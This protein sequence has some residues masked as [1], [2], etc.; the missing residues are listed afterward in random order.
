[1]YICTHISDRYSERQR[2][3]YKVKYTFVYCWMHIAI[4]VCTKVYICENE[5]RIY[6]VCVYFVCWACTWSLSGRWLYS[7]EGSK[8][9]ID[10]PIR[11]LRRESGQCLS[12]IQSCH[13]TTPLIHPQSFSAIESRHRVLPA[14]TFFQRFKHSRAHWAYKCDRHIDRTVF[15]PVDSISFFFFVSWSIFF[16]FFFFPFH[17]FWI[18]YVF[19]WKNFMTSQFLYGAYINILI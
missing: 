11:M 9:F 19:E 13:P 8:N 18:A 5:S 17:F 4:T 15:V 1:M 10:S 14:P 6:I 2:G 3:N 7:Y 12:Y 16:F